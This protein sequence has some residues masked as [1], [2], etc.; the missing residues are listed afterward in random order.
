MK[1]NLETLHL[2]Q[3]FGIAKL[4]RESIILLSVVVIIITNILISHIGLRIDLSRGRAYTLST[5]TKKILKKASSPIA[6]TFY[7]SSN[8]PTQ[9]LPIKTEVTDILNEYQKQ[10]SKVQTQVQDPAK[11]QKIAQQAKDDGIPELQFSQLEQDKYNVTASMFGIAIQYNGKTEIIPQATDTGS[12]EYGL[13]SSIYRLLNTELPKVGIV[14]QEST[15]NPQTDTLSSLRTVL[16]QQAQA[17]DLDISSSSAQ[18]LDDS[19]KTVLVFDNNQKIYSND[20]IKKLEN[21]IDNKGNVIVFADGV[22]V[23]SDLNGSATSANHNL[24]NF[25][26][27]YGIHLN[28]DLILS[29]SYELVNFGNGVVSFVSPYPYWVKASVLPKQAGSFA[30]SSHLTLPWVS[31]LTLSKKNGFNVEP[32]VN[33]VNQSWEQTANFTLF[34]QNIKQPDPKTFK[35]Y[36]LIAQSVNKKG[37]ALVVIPSSRFVTEDFVQRQND[38]LE[39]VVNYID[40]LASSGAL[41]GIRHRTVDFYQLPTLNDSQKNMFKFATILLLPILF[42][43]YGAWRLAKRK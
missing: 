2:Q 36:T 39:F 28:R 24:F 42:A 30:N 33:S 9:L 17:E 19:Y 37:G 8:L 11:D 32:I 10:S 16:A 4:K 3:Q 12:L 18:T 27:N 25:I 1:I 41:S 23:P 40:N 7:V 22:W 14:G 6:I 15:L 29:S 38:N 26:S 5:S 13:T 35:Q 21:Y 20:E 34:P 43:L 31:S